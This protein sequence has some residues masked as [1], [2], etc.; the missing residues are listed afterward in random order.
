MKKI[1]IVI[2][3]IVLSGCQS[4][5]NLETKCDCLNTF[6]LRAVELMEDEGFKVEK[7]DFRLLIENVEVKTYLAF[8]KIKDDK[9]LDYVLAKCFP[10]VNKDNYNKLSNPE[11]MRKAGNELLEFLGKECEKE[12]EEKSALLRD[13]MLEKFKSFQID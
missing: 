6:Y 13:E 8:E 2:V 1:F 12:N 11:E 10:D 5:I 9:G 3:S 7:E 4:E